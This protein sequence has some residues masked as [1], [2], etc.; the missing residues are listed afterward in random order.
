MKFESVLSQGLGCRC[1]MLYYI[2]VASVMIMCDL[3]VSLASLLKL[4]V[5]NM[6]YGN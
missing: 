1:K 5:G 3:I 6:V 4:P 2:L